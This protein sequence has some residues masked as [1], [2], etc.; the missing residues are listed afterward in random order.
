MIVGGAR[1]AVWTAR[2]LE[3]TLAQELPGERIVVVSNR[4]PY[5]H[6]RAGDGSIRVVRPAGGVVAAL[7]PVLRA[8]RGTWVAHGSG[9]ADRETVDARGT[10]AV[11]PGEES[12]RLRRVWLSAAEERGYY[13]GLANEGLWP[14]C[15]L[16]DNR[17]VFRTTDWRHYQDANRKFADAA[18]AEIDSGDAIVLVQDYHLALAPRLIRERVPGAT[19][20]TFWHIPWPHAERFRICPWRTEILDGLLGSSIV[21]F[22]TPSDCDHFLDSAEQLLEASVDRREDSVSQRGSTSLVRPYPISVEWPGDIE[23]LPGA[24]DCRAELV[25]QLGLGPDARIGVGVDRLDYTKGLEERMGAVERLLERSPALRGRFTFVQLAAPSRTGIE[26]YRKYERAVEAAV[27]RVNR[28]FGRGSYRPVH[29][30]RAHHDSASIRRCYRAADVCYVSSLHDGMNL[31]AKEFVAARDDERGVLVLS[32]FTGAARELKQALVVNPYDVDAAG[33][34]LARALAMPW[35]EQRERMRAMRA[36]VAEFNVYH[37][38]G[39]L[40]SDAAGVRRHVRPVQ[41]LRDSIATAIA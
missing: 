26:R 19:V 39:R 2:R 13:Q 1:G 25:R 18:C 10:L 33:A 38:A 5:V 7:E 17:P 20:I 41:Q 6:E 22:Q 11:P 3:R 37:W 16:A 36:W 4:A 31:V 14:L 21:G 28:R 23:G 30:L 8:C 27:D 15:H 24:A 35:R 34:A 9:S 29:L 12:Y 40:L 32:E